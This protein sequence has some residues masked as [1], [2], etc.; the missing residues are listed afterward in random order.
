MIQNFKPLSIFSGCTAWFV[1]DLVRNLE[2]RFS[3]DTEG[4]YAVLSF[5]TS[6]TITMNTQ[7]LST[8]LEISGKLFAGMLVFVCTFLLQASEYQKI[9]PV[10]KVYGPYFI[11]LWTVKELPGL[12]NK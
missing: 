7:T 5:S 2:D 8:L 6:N 1:S 4:S 3:H 9:L 12:L 11:I 10:K